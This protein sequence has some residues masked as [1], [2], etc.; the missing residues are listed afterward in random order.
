MLELTFNNFEMKTNIYL[1]IIGLLFM[2][3]SLLS[4]SFIGV[5]SGYAYLSKEK[6][7]G[8][9]IEALVSK[10]LGK[11]LNIEL[12]SGFFYGNQK[13]IFRDDYEGKYSIIDQNFQLPSEILNI[14]KEE[15]LSIHYGN[16]VLDPKP[17]SY[18][19]LDFGIGLRYELIKMKKIDHSVKLSLLY[20]YHDYNKYEEAIEV[21]YRLLGSYVSFLHYIPYYKHYYDIGVNVNYSLG[22]ALTDRIKF[23]ASISG[24]YYTSTTVSFALKAGLGI[25]L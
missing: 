8:M 14:E 22:Y 6:M 3:N 17:D 15:Y 7:G 20:S 13:G 16:L 23:V 9:D 10:K 2:A 18:Y 19:I 4:Q 21:T 11:H 25:R 5:S 24:K 1:L 12:T